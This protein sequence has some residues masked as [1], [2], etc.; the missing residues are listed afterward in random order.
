M[1]EVALLCPIMILTWVGIDYF[2]NGYARRLN[3][4]QAAATDAWKMAYSNDGSCLSIV[5]KLV[6]TNVDVS[7][8][9]GG[10]KIGGASGSIGTTNDT[11][12]ASSNASQTQNSS[13]T[14]VSASAVREY[15]GNTGS[16]LLNAGHVDVTKDAVTG[17][18]SP[19]GPNAPRG[20]VHGGAFIMCNEIVPDSKNDGDIF[21]A[22]SKWMKSFL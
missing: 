17:R 5:G 3:T 20:S 2:R 4:V 22:M 12:A 10:T 13:G 14:G 15:Q 21:S 18:I 16:L 19:E 8:N 7:V 1:V 6:D 9:V 11:S